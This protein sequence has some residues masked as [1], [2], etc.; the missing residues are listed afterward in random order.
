[1]LLCHIPACRCG[2]EAAMA[3]AADAN[4]TTPAILAILIKA[5]SFNAPSILGSSAG[6]AK[7][8]SQKTT[9]ISALDF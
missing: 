5:E 7:Q 3:G 9:K 4:R 1:V 2:S 6:S 8:V